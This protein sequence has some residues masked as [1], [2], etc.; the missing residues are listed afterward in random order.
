[1]L[2]C[3]GEYDDDM[4]RFL[5]LLRQENE[6]GEAEGAMGGTLISSWFLQNE[7]IQMQYGWN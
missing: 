4:M 2:L 5:D 3:T 6:K 1:M 7:G